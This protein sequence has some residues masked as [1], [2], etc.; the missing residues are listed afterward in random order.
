MFIHSSG[1][2]LSDP[3]SRASQLLASSM[4][5]RGNP[6][7]RVSHQ[8][9]ELTRTSANFPPEEQQRRL[10]VPLQARAG[11]RNIANAIYENAV[12]AAHASSGSY[13]A[14]NRSS[15]LSAHS[16]QPV[17]EDPR[18]KY[19]ATNSLNQSMARHEGLSALPEILA[20]PSSRMG[21][22][23]QN[24]AKTP[25]SQSWGQKKG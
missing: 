22:Q 11:E 19:Q 1:Q 18:S 17:K 2:T 9:T 10:Q 20:N 8:L 6:D 12:A 14:H 4:P 16:S 7:S 24:N 3:K 25:N 5:Q 23:Q 13:K 21:Q 15:K